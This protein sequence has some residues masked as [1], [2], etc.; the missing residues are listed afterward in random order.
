[1][2]DSGELYSGDPVFRGMT[3][4]VTVAGMPQL[5]FAG[6]LILLVLSVTAV[7]MLK[8][9]WI[10]AALFAAIGIVLLMAARIACERDPLVFRYMVLNLRTSAP[11][12]LT[13][14]RW[15]GMTSVPPTPLRKR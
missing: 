12:L 8:W 11:H 3:R 10:V 14:G 6:L 1:M 4:P 7:F 9:H 5:V 15:R 2:T 13:R